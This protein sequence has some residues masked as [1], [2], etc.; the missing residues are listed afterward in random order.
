MSYG[1]RFQVYR[2]HLINQYFRQLLIKNFFFPIPTGALQKQSIYVYAVRWRLN[3]TKLSKINKGLIFPFA[4][5][6]PALFNAYVS[7]SNIS[8]S[9]VKVSIGI[10][11]LRAKFCIAPVRNACVKK[12]PDN[13]KVGGLP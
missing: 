13:Q 3:F 2:R 9:N 12:K 7:S 5:S 4:L 8:W 10:L 6:T 1:H 11:Y